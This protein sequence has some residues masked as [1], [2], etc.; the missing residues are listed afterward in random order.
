MGDSEDTVNVLY[1]GD[2]CL[3]THDIMVG[4]VKA[5]QS[6]ESVVMERIDPNEQ[7]P[8]FRYVVHSTALDRKF[9]LS[10]LDLKLA[11]ITPP[12]PSGGPVGPPPGAWAPTS[13]QAEGLAVPVSGA[14]TAALAV[15]PKQGPISLA[16]YRNR[17][18]LLAVVALA[19]SL[20]LVFGIFLALRSR[21]HKTGPVAAVDK[22]LTL[23][24]KSDLQGMLECW[25]AN[26]RAIAEPFIKSNFISATN[27]PQEKP[28][29]MI[30]F[31]QKDLDYRTVVNGNSATVDIKAKPGT[32]GKYAGATGYDAM[33]ATLILD[34]GQWYLTE[35]RFTR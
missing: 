6:G 14:G 8:Q 20:V 30:A 12:Q 18:K 19:G 17:R 23:A 3:V 7:R 27:E 1:P 33:Q 16:P 34:N 28:M 11:P 26:K 9:Q 2:T 25:E 29:V 5:F 35:M 32:T 13:P 22:F 15:A 24:D 31:S 10:D 21:S 4:D